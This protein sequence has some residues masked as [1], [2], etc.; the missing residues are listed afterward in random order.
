MQ[1]TCAN[2]TKEV[3]GFIR[4]C[5]VELLPYAIEGKAAYINYIDRNEIKTKWDP[6]S[7]FWNWKSMEPLKGGKTVP[8][9][10]SVEAMERLWIQYASL[11]DPEHLI[12]L[13]TEQDVMRE[14]LNFAS[15]FVVTV[16]PTDL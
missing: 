15:I 5:Q 16:S 2:K 13:E 7:V 14:M 11:L 4:K 3:Y 8:N 10:G 12:P 6:Y 1:W 9:P